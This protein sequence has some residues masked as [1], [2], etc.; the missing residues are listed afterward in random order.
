MNENFILSLIEK[1]NSSPVVS[2]EL[3]QG[4]DKLVLKKKEAFD[5]LPK[6]TAPVLPG[7]IPSPAVHQTAPVPPAQASASAASPAPAGND[8]EPAEDSSLIQVKS[9]I[10]GTFYR[11][12]SPDSPVYV[13]EGKSVKKGEPLCIL[14]A[15][16]MMNTLES[17]FDCT[18]EKILVQNGDLVEFEQPLFLVR[19]N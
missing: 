18:V 16:K 14:E 9:P 3:K 11:A 5:R 13:E 1:F 7:F 12:P 10:V 4:E 19:K 2:L 17:E 6:E 15:M 8:S